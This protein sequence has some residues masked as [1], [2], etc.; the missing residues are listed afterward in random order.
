MENVSATVKAT[1]QEA[2]SICCRCED[3]D[4]T[5]SL[6]STFEEF[7]AMAVGRL[8]LPFFNGIVPLRW[9]AALS[10]ALPDLILMSLIST[11]ES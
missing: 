10:Q 11:G 9:S 1:G 4:Q 2:L 6:V 5:P 7:N 8:G 3:V